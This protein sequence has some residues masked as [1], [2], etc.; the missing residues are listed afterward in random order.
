MKEL[1]LGRVQVLRLAA[2]EHPSA[3]ADR[4]PAG[5]ADREHDPVAEPVVEAGRLA[6]RRVGLALDDQSGAQQDLPLV[7]GRA[8]PVEQPIPSRRREADAEALDD[9]V[10]QAALRKVLT[11]LGLAAERLA[12]VKGG[13]FE[14]NVEFVVGLRGRGAAFARHLET[15]AGREFLDGLDEAEVV[16]LHHEAERGAVGAAAEAVIELL[17]GAHRERG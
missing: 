8:V 13:A 12:E 10:R 6:A 7:V 14:R 9:V 2:V 1:G 4:A 3:E 17:V 16:V 15:G 11:G 5:V